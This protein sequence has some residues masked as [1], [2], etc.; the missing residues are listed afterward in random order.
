MLV[1]QEDVGDF[2]YF[3]ESGLLKSLQIQEDGS[4][5]LL[6]ILT[7]GETFL[8]HNRVSSKQYPVT[9]M[10]LTDA[11]VIRYSALEWYKSLQC[12]PEQYQRI[13]KTLQEQFW[14]MQQHIIILTSPPQSSRVFVYFV[15]GFNNIFLINR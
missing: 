6:N 2:L 4:N 1:Y 3:L 9:I 13:A 5:T 15:S 12:E 14:M 8:F 11:K 7:P 10:A